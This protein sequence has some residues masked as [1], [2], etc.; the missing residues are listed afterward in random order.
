MGITLFISL[1]TTRLILNSLGVID[2]GIFNLVGGA[3]LMLGFL[4]STM[5][6]ATQ[7][8]MSFANGLGNIEKEIKVFNI[9]IILHFLIA[10]LFGIVLVIMS[11]FFLMVF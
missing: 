5:A 2:Y 8:F 4:N 7:R 3:V 9:S 1:Y 11:Y 10:I 6:S